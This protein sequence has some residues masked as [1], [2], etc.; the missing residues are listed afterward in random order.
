MLFS[1]TKIAPFACGSIGRRLSAVFSSKVHSLYSVFELT[2]GATHQD[3][4]EAFYRL[5]KI[6]H[7][8]V[9]NDPNSRA[10]FHELVKAYEI[11]G[12]PVKRNEY[13]RGLIHARRDSVHHFSEDGYTIDSLKDISS[14]SFRSFYVKQHNRTVDAFWKRRSDRDS[15]MSALELRKDHATFICVIIMTL[16]STPLLA[17]VFSKYHEKPIEFIQHP[18]D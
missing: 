7:P 1:A 16:F 14:N 9:T 2:D 8:D 11:L 13:D 4:K 15:T 6:Y 18:V 17:Y 12:N 3:I 5:S 10:K